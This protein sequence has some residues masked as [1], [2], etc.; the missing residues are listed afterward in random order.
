MARRKKKS[1]GLLR[2]L[3]WA[4]GIS[5]VVALAVFG[6][7]YMWVQNYL[8]SPAFRD[9]LAKNLGKATHSRV[10]LSDLT[11]TGSSLY[12]PKAGL[13]PDHPGGWKAVEADG[14]QATLDLSTWRQGV[15]SVPRVDID[16][17]RLELASRKDTAAQPPVTEQEV[18]EAKEKGAESLPGW[19]RGWI[20]QRTEVSS[21]NVQSFELLPPTGGQ[22]ALSEMK[23]NAK[24]ATGETT[25]LLRGE[26]GT[27]HVPGVAEPFKVTSVS[28]SVDGRNLA[29]NDS[30]FHWIG[31]SEITGRGDVPFETGAN[32]GFKG[33]L[34]NLDLRHVLSHDWAGRV[35]GILEGDY[36]I[37]AKGSAPLALEIAARIKNGVLQNI[38][39]LDRVADFT[40]TDRFRRVVLDEASGNVSHQGDT[41]RITRLTLQSNG[42]VRVEGEVLLKGRDIEGELY[43]GVFP[44]TLR[45]IPGAQT[46]VFTER[47]RDGPPGF[48][49]TRV[50]ITGSMDDP[51]EDL[52]S[53]LLIAMGQ[54]VADV[55]MSV[56]S[57][58][59]GVLEKAGGPA[60]RGALEG[61]KEIIHGAGSVIEKGVDTVKDLVPFL[62]K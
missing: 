55:P 54:S 23:L 18:E 46:H 6:L 39:V 37:S 8:H 5:V 24:P 50:K 25:W 33:R 12:V 29:L 4:G 9:L 2:F 42:L 36:D 31:D 52:S 61:G 14:I 16:W 20:P 51:K 21:V 22:L 59:A 49:W 1:N 38:P 13:D 7:G 15:W 11:L 58:G 27:L 30:L 48:V 28:A 26:G 60:G 53:R 19:L 40:H 41:T 56:L 43:V 57:T 34:T 10:D 3:L 17:L 32:W 45:W 44:E 62:H 47:M 35:S